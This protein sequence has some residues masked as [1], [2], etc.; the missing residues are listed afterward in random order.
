MTTSD[1][2]NAGQGEGAQA[3]V[4]GQADTP[5]TPIRQDLDAAETGKGEMLARLGAE[6]VVEAHQAYGKTL[7]RPKDARAKLLADIV[8][9]KT[10]TRETLA[11]VKRLGFE[12]VVSVPQASTEF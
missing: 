10:L 6:V 4:T 3:L 11:L 5:H 12:I 9:T 8:G 1:D 2:N 7:Y